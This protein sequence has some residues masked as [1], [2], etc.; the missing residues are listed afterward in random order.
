MFLKLR[1]IGIALVVCALIISTAYTPS[2]INC[3]EILQNSIVAIDKIQTLKFHLKCN[4]RIKGMLVATESQVKMKTSPRSIYIYLKGP[5]LLWV[6]GKNNG[7]ALINPNGFPFINLSLDPT[8]SIM[9]ENQHHTINEV[10]FKY[11]S[12]I[13]KTYLTSAGEEFDNFFHCEGIISFD[14]TDC[15]FITAEYP[16][17]KYIDYTVQEGETLVSIAEKL[18]VSDYMLLEINTDKGRNYHAIKAG[19]K[20]RVPN[21]YCRKLI[22]YID[23][24]TFLP[25]VIKVYDDKGLFESYEYRNLQV[26]PNIADEEFTKEYKGYKF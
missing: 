22:L 2:N 19:Q 24:I 26:N 16:D 10:G 23:K 3:K 11:F 4:E 9:R 18:M 7:N 8:G 1:F 20:I 17:F 5:E 14:N 12:G 6:N 21:M 25:R 13:I 15:W